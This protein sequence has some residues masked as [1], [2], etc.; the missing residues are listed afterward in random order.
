MST[1]ETSQPSAVERAARQAAGQAAARIAKQALPK[2]AAVLGAKG[3]AVVAA[4][5]ALIAL[6]VGL[7]VLIAVVGAAFQTTTAVWP[8]PIATDAA[9]N[10]QA[11]GWAISSRYGWR[12][13]PQTGGAEF[14]DGIDLANPNGGCPFGYHCGAP[15]IF[16]GTV[17]YVGWDVAASGDPSKTGGG[18]LVIVANGA[19]DHQTIYAHLEPYRL[20]VQLQG[21]IDDDYGRYD[22]YADYQPIGRGPLRPDLSNGALEMTCVNDMPNFIPTRSG[23]GTAVFLYDRPAS[24]T[25]TVVWGQRGG[26]WRGWIA[27]QPGARAGDEQRAELHWQTP[28]DPGQRAQDVALRFRAH[29]VPPPPPPPITDTATLTPEAGA[30]AP[31]AAR[32]GMVAPGQGAASFGEQRNL[33]PSATQAAAPPGSHTVQPRSCETLPGGWTRCSWRMRDIP[34]ER[35]RFASMPEPW[36]VAAQMAPGVQPP[37]YQHEDDSALPAIVATPTPSRAP[38]LPVEREE[39][40]GVGGLVRQPQVQTSPTAVSIDNTITIDAT[41]PE[42]LMLHAPDPPELLGPVLTITSSVAEQIQITAR[43]EDPAMPGPT[44][45]GMTTIDMPAGTLTNYVVSQIGVTVAPGTAPGTQAC[46]SL[47]WHGLTS[48]THGSTRAC[49]VTADPQAISPTAPPGDAG[50]AGL[51]CAPQTLVRL[52]SVTAPNPRLIAPAAASFAAVRAEVVERTGVDALAILADVLRAPSFTTGKAGV[53]ATSW[54]KAGRAVDLNQGGPFLRVAE[55]RMFRLYVNNVDITAIFE[56][57]GWQ[58][59]PVQGHRRVVAL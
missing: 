27:D 22:D 57:H 24:C 26:D 21:R 1:E 20:Y 13:D 23:A 49:T 25:T 48:G 36:I 34:T 6:V 11:S 51:D 7:V 58:R 47:D 39:R 56:A 41:L 31:I 32:S 12:D 10:Y 30:P 40:L 55:G 50:S 9:G 16:D 54:H 45:Q 53:L 5:I 37:N 29:L 43:Y 59:I 4:V 15:S 2:L 8:V 19:Q 17:Q 35:E 38:T 14:H 42:R 18:E 46:L 33:A 28:I 52:P 3:A 44:D